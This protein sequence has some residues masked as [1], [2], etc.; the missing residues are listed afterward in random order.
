MYPPDMTT[1]QELDALTSKELHDRATDLAK[2]R[3]DIEFLWGLLRTIPAAESAAGEL[4]RS[5]VDIMKVT[6][7]LNDLR[8]ADE[9]RLADALR[10]FYIDYL[11]GHERPPG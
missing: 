10:P 11:L 7:L 2:H 3:L 4:D 1:R 6:P 8:D 9:G 5:E